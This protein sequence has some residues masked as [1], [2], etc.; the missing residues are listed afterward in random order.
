MHVHILQFLHWNLATVL[1][2]LAEL[3]ITGQTA[4]Y[5]TLL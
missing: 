3:E 1:S 4:G 2:V 5:E